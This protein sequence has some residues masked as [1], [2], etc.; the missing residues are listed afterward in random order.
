[1]SKTRSVKQ[2]QTPAALGT[3]PVNV[4]LAHLVPD[5]IVVGELSPFA[6]HLSRFAER[7]CVEIGEDF[8]A[9]LMRQCANEVDL[10]QVTD[11]RGDERQLREAALSQNALEHE[12]A[13]AR[14]GC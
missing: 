5:H 9:Q 2:R 1:M 8:E 14:R 12:V 4:L 3:L 11:G 7:G 13:V 6:A 10:D